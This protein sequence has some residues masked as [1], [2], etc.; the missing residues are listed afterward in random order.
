MQQ[1][2]GQEE[3]Q[4][5][6]VLDCFLAAQ[7]LESND[8]ISLAIEYYVEI[9]QF[10]NS[11]KYKNKR[12]K[13]EHEQN[14][15]DDPP[16]I[17]IL[18]CALNSLAGIYMDQEQ[19]DVAMGYL[20]KSVCYWNEN[21]MS[22]LNMGNI[23]REHRSL[24]KAIEYYTRIVQLSKTNNHF[25]KNAAA[26]DKEEDIDDNDWENIWIYGP[27]KQC[28]ERAY[29]MSA[30]CLHQIGNYNEAVKYLKPFNVKYRVHPNVWIEAC[31]KQASD[32]I[33]YV[34]SS[35]SIEHR[36]RQQISDELECVK[37]FHNA[38]PNKLKLDLQKMFSP[39]S[40]YWNGTNYHERGYYS[41][42]YDL[43]K[44]PSNTIEILI[45]Y[46]LPIIQKQVPNETFCGGEWWVHSRPEGKN[47]GHQLHLDTEEN[48][49]EIKK[50]IVHPRVSSV[51]YLSPS[52]NGG[53]TVVFDQTLESNYNGKPENHVS[54]YVCK[55]SDG[56]FL[57]F[58]GRKIHGVLPSNPLSDDD[59]NSNNNFTDNNNNNN[60]SA[61][62]RRKISPS[63][64]KKTDQ[65]QR[66]TLM[67]GFWTDDVV[68]IGKRI[69]LGPCGPVPPVSTRSVQWP[70][71][72]RSPYYTEFTK[73]ERDKD[74]ENGINNMKEM[75]V[76]RIYPAWENINDGK[77]SNSGNL[78]NSAK[79]EIP[80]VIDQ[81]FFLH[82]M[83]EFKVHLL[84]RALS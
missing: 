54:A 21:L 13:Y 58:D 48:T 75:P 2:E 5:E 56:G 52:P 66:L 78:N 14:K 25:N 77:S 12:L 41:F 38:I 40:L 33:D 8:E 31:K 37:M 32:K 39:T 69:S 80:E 61:S 57:I 3:F 20:L 65:K 46:L 16:S 15:Y 36:S 7:N 4:E 27:H 50:K 44:R 47:L 49:L 17:L 26:L 63:F 6:D 28:V 19:Y 43:K 67:I 11:A 35:T 81:R 72:L 73:A 9:V 62:K 74:F 53:C 83:E 42:W 76:N 59:M 1:E 30:L 84:Q 34:S 55:P 82:D 45:Q 70:T 23:E 60:N 79:L 18:S 24:S 64:M 71:I 68:K 29:Y 10:F 51:V 22:L